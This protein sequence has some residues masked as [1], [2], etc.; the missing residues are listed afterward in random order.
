MEAVQWIEEAKEHCGTLGGQQRLDLP[1]RH[2]Q[3]LGFPNLPLLE[4][5][6]Q[7]WQIRDGRLSFTSYTAHP[8][9]PKLSLFTLFTLICSA[10]PEYNPS[11]R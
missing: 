4:G 10:H 3:T 2:R 11:P 9:F 1:T 7:L 6:G 8:T 5:Q